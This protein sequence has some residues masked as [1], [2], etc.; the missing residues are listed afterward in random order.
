MSVPRPSVKPRLSTGGPHHKNALLRPSAAGHRLSTAA[1]RLS[2]IAGHRLS[3]IAGH[4]ISSGAYHFTN[5]GGRLTSG[6]ARDD[7]QDAGGLDDDWVPGRG[8][9]KPPDQLELS[10]AEL[11][12]EVTRV[13]T[14]QNPHAPH[15]I[16]RYSFRERAYKALSSVDQLAVHF[17]LEGALLHRD[18]D[19]ARR[20]LARLGEVALEA[21]T[22]V[23]EGEEPQEQAPVTTEEGE[24][25]PSVSHP[26]KLTNQ[27][28]FSER[29]SQTLN[30]P[31]RDR[32]TQ[33]VPPARATFSANATQWQIY[34]AYMEELA[35]QE[36]A[37]H[38]GSSAA[39]KEET[40]QHVPKLPV[41][42]LVVDLSK[43]A[44]STK[45]V[46]R[47]VNQNTF[48]EISQDFKYFE[49]MSDEFR[50]QE[51]TLLPL[52]NFHNEET[53]GLAVTAL[54]W[55]PNYKD[56]FAAGYGSYD[57]MNQGRGL[58]LLYSLKN[59]S[60][61]E[62]IFN[63]KSGV[64]C[65]DI[66]E[67]HPYLLAVGL[68]DGN[69]ALYN[70]K[71]PGLLPNYKSSAGK[72]TD[73]V[74]QV[75][76]Q[77]DDLDNNLNFFSVSSDGRVVSWT[78][79]KNELVH[80]DVISLQLSDPSKDVPAA[81][82]LNL[83]AC[84]TAFD[85]HKK[86]NYMFLVGTEEGKIHKCSKTYSS[87]FLDTYDAHDMAVDAVYWNTFHPGVFIS[88]SSD[89]TVKIWDENVNTPMFIFDLDAAVSD[90]AWAPYSSTVFAAVTT[91]GKV[92]VFDLNINKYE[93]ICEQTVVSRRKTRVTHIKFNS[94]F[95]VIIVGDDKGNTISLKLSPNLRK[96]PKV[97][98]GIQEPLKGPEYEIAKLDKLLSLVRDPEIPVPK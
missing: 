7:G 51:G 65:L 21:P 53:K 57:F 4:R 73:P 61:P 17:S 11:R 40:P 82:H 9:L 94:S 41:D 79:V 37:K 44:K 10:E 60:Y 36:R 39:K 91:D 29:A 59:P 25:P 78:L 33:T 86:K 74:W 90:V 68:Y 56:L 38:K 13:L 62:F 87:Q 50:E 85:F 75:R 76:W 30:N 66:H 28:N 24:E 72:H 8:L 67:D 77:K 71:K 14:S 34:D 88:C 98:R 96:L 80:I 55:S 20:Q 46:E 1:H 12:Q 22:Q 49:D 84:G 81:L 3:T 92:H 35:K 32:T 19:E 93:A 18:S 48:D 97:K 69:V 15:N 26:K 54:C 70:L 83:Y 47:M 43:L 6:R 95:P 16:V 52:W 58:L 27:F 89:W 2:T 64:M 45:I 5:V 23:V 42:S 63:T 31:Q